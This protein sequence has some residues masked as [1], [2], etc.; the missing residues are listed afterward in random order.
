[1]NFS[2]SIYFILLLSCISFLTFAQHESYTLSGTIKNTFGE[3]LPG[4]SI[5]IKRLGIGTVTDVNGRYQIDGLNNGVHNIQV[6]HIGYE[7]SNITITVAGD[8]LEEN[9]LLTLPFCN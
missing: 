5:Q 9:F 6:N 2:N 7:T 3:P 1:M 4:A 8:D